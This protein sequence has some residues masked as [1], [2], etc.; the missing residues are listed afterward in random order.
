[1]LATGGASRPPPTNASSFRRRSRT[2]QAIRSSTAS[3]FGVSANQDSSD[4]L[5]GPTAQDNKNVGTCRR[6]DILPSR[7]LHVWRER[8]RFFLSGSARFHRH[9]EQWH[10]S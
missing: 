5:S 7:L 6:P 3:P 2:T 10:E 1:M 9:G 4:R 8:S